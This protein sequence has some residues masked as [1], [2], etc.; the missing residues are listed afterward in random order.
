MANLETPLVSIVIPC[1]NN[2]NTIRES[3][4]SCINQIYKNFEIIIVNDGST[5]NSCEVIQSL[6][7]QFPQVKGFR[8]DNQGPARARNFGS[9]FAQGKYIVFL[10]ADDIFLSTFLSECI[11]V[12]NK[13]P[14]VDIVYSMVEKF[15][16]EEGI[17][18]L[19]KYSL[20]MM[21]LANCFPIFSMVSLEKFRD[22]GMFDEELAHAE[23]WEMWIRM[24]ARY[25][26]AYKI[27]KPLVLYRKRVA[28]DSI[29]DLNAVH[30]Y[31]DYTHLYIYNKHYE[32]Y[33]KYS[34]SINDLIVTKQLTLSY[35]EEA[36]KYKKKYYNEWYRKLIYKWFL[37]KKK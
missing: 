6:V 26:K 28:K 5:D 15:E 29:T 19:P 11:H 1:Y 23:D 34:M 33:R 16:G 24:T 18:E 35:K 30:N 2:A 3:V 31:A 13:D 17:W 22:I 36:L 12:F 27:D 4:E 32:L 37:G 14:E 9:S 25:A 21:L 8:Q 7:K 10:D 20:E